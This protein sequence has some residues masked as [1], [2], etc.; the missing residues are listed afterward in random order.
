V[1]QRLPKTLKE[2]KEVPNVGEVKIKKFGA[3]ILAI[4]DEVT[5]REPSPE[6]AKD[7]ANGGHAQRPSDTLPDLAC[8]D[9]SDDD[10]YA[11]TQG[12][13]KQR[14]AEGPNPRAMDVESREPPANQG[15][16]TK[17]PPPQQQQQMAGG[18]TQP[19]AGGWRMRSNKPTGGEAPHQMRQSPQGG[20]D[21]TMSEL[22]SLG[23]SAN[24]THSVSA[25]RRQNVPSIPIGAAGAS[26]K[27]SP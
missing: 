12:P 27:H 5:G 26:P 24:R 10:E 15:W 25:D 8:F 22:F 6:A 14:K 2:L 1:V 20:E 21:T 3:K 9:D 11:F 19:I 17:I 16:S 18:P 13:A 4:I 7:S 23:A